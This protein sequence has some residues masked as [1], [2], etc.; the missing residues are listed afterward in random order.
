MRAEK[1]SGRIDESATAVGGEGGVH[2]VPAVGS[3]G[4]TGPAQSALSDPCPR[5]PKSIGDGATLW[6]FRAGHHRRSA[7]A[8][9]VSPSK[10]SLGRNDKPRRRGDPRKDSGC[11]AT[12][13]ESA[14]AMASVGVHTRCRTSAPDLLPAGQPDRPRHQLPA[15]QRSAWPCTLVVSSVRSEGPDLP[16]RP[17]RYLTGALALRRGLHNA[18]LRAPPR[19]LAAALTGW[20]QELRGLWSATARSTVQN[21]SPLR[22]TSGA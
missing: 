15:R 14:A 8:S 7:R 22:S 4:R 16:A 18:R 17:S 13:G 6:R 1:Q 3:G 2:R 19:S 9:P 12:H 11:A 20:R 21:S 10:R 5:V